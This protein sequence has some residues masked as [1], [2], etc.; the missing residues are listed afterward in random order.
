MAWVL[1]LWKTHFETRGLDRCWPDQTIHEYPKFCWHLSKLQVTTTTLM[2]NRIAHAL[3]ND[4]APLVGYSLGNAHAADSPRLR[5]KNPAGWQILHQKKAPCETC[6][7]HSSQVSQGHFGKSSK[8][9]RSTTPCYE[10]HR[11][12]GLS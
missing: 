6:N 4:F 12:S 10:T 1:L 7:F 9:G 3:S 5:H 2:S 11:S 8:W